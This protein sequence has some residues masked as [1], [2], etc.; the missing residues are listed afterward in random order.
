MT[1]LMIPGTDRPVTLSINTSGIPDGALSNFIP[2]LLH[3]LAEEY[4]HGSGSIIY[5]YRNLVG[6]DEVYTILNSF[7]FLYGQYERHVPSTRDLESMVDYVYNHKYGVSSYRPTIALDCKQPMRGLYL[8]MCHAWAAE[9][10][11]SGADVDRFSAAPGRICS[12]LANFQIQWLRRTPCGGS[13][14]R[15]RS[16]E[17]IVGFEIYY[18]LDKKQVMAEAIAWISHL[19][20]R[21]PGAEAVFHPETLAVNSLQFDRYIVDDDGI[22]VTAK[23]RLR[24]LLGTPIGWFVIARNPPIGVNSP[25]TTVYGALR[26]G[27]IK[28]PK[29]RKLRCW[30]DDLAVQ[31]ALTF[32]RANGI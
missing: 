29:A 6:K 13:S 2:P 9:D 5:V 21:F 14:L 10:E 32:K 12:A 31:I 4:V 22:L 23:H 18:A 3:K 15:L 24:L 7:V 27:G 17:N 16:P 26:Y 1:A 30:T 19:E 11:L 25:V 20:S 8:D 28:Y